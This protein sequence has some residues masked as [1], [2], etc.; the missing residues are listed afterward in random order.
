MWLGPRPN[1][2]IVRQG[3]PGR[4]E[5]MDPCIFHPAR[6]LI[7]G[8][9]VCL[10]ATPDGKIAGAVTPSKPPAA[11]RSSKHRRCAISTPGLRRENC[12]RNSGEGMVS[13][14]RAM[15]QIDF[16]DEDVDAILAYLYALAI[17]K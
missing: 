13:Q 6:S 17:K 14:H 11:V 3:T 7:V 1:P 12:R 10:S 2:L 5:Q 8:L 15:P 4:V 9:L 16:S